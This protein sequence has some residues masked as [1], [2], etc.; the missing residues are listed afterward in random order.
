MKVKEARGLLEEYSGDSLYQAACELYQE[1]V[2]NVINLRSHGKKPTVGVVKSAIK[3]MKEWFGKV[4]EGL[5]W[6]NPEVPSNIVKWETSRVWVKYKMIDPEISKYR[7]RTRHEVMKGSKLPLLEALTS[8]SL[9][10][11]SGMMVARVQEDVRK[12]G[13]VEGKRKKFAEQY[14]LRLCPFTT[15]ERLCEHQKTYSMVEG[16][17]VNTTE[18]VFICS[19]DKCVKEGGV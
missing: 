16:L 2:D 8:E 1:E 9:D 6:E 10:A 5:S 11:I 3:Q 4:A 18:L 12:W 7:D 17:P 19:I 15:E 13:E 14:G